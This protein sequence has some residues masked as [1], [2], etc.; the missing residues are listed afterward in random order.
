MTRQVRAVTQKTVTG[1]Y[2]GAFSSITVAEHLT[3]TNNSD[4]TKSAKGTR[5]SAGGAVWSY[6][7]SA[8]R[9]D[10]GRFLVFNFDNVLVASINELPN[11]NTI[12][13]KDISSDGCLYMGKY[14]IV[15]NM[16]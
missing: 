4:I 2:V 6:R 8:I 10:T 1:K 13:A 7:K 14:V 3:G 9:R 16:N 11:L 12:Q 15:Q 5:K